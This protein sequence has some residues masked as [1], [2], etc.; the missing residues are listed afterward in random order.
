MSSF[1]FLKD[2][3]K[4]KPEI[5]VFIESYAPQTDAQRKVFAA[6]RAYY[7]VIDTITEQLVLAQTEYRISAESYEI[8]K[9][10]GKEV[11]TKGLREIRRDLLDEIGRLREQL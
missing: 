7:S 11:G 9:R 8:L 10:F 4:E 3:Q 5:E 1:D 2:L 6:I